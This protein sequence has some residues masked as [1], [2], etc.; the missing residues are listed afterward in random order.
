MRPVLHSVEVVMVMVVM[1]VMVVIV[2][3]VGSQ[4]EVGVA[5]ALSQW[6]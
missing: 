5:C 4:V 2:M 1:M 6:D 3:M